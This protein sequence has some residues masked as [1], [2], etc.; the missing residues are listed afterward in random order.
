MSAH[1]ERLLQYPVCF[2]CLLFLFL[3]SRCVADIPWTISLIKHFHYLL[4]DRIIVSCVIMWIDRCLSNRKLACPAP[5]SSHPKSHLDTHSR[6]LYICGSHVAERCC[7][8]PAPHASVVLSHCSV[9]MCGRSAR[10]TFLRVPRSSVPVQQ[11]A[12]EILSANLRNGR[13][14]NR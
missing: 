12:L 3:A 2:F 4:I 5:R 7:A 9:C 6:L 14:Q 11:A 13:L 10:E 1:F 8:T